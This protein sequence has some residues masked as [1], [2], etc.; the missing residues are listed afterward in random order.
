MI[1]V[2]ACSAPLW[3]NSEFSAA[4]KYQWP[5]RR[6]LGHD[7]SWL[8]S[9]ELSW[10][11]RSEHSDNS[12]QLNSTQLNWKCSELEK[13]SPTSWVELSRFVRAFR[14]PDPTQLNQMSWV[15]L[16]WVGRFELGFTVGFRIV[17]HN[18]AKLFAFAG[19]VFSVSPAWY[20]FC[21]V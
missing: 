9:V 8:C 7:W 19:N 17:L 5:C 18:A 11:G 3:L 4:C 6:K 2:L 21:G 20:Q 12:T 14:A 1:L 10:V 15:E 16:S 13:N